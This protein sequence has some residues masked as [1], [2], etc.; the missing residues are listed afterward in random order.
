MRLKGLVFL[1]VCVLLLTCQY[2]FGQC[3]VSFVSLGKGNLAIHKKSLG[4]KKHQFQWPK[5]NFKLGDQIVHKAKRFAD[6]SSCINYKVIWVWSRCGLKM[7]I[8]YPL[9]SWAPFWRVYLFLDFSCIHLNFW[10]LHHFNMLVWSQIWWVSWSFQCWGLGE[11]MNNSCKWMSWPTTTPSMRVTWH[12]M[13]GQ[14]IATSHD[15]TP[16]GGSVMEFSYFREI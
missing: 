2:C 1:C 6:V 10:G 13:S 8:G 12:R 7:R 5:A 16:N 3:F 4:G 9:T 14:I 15:L 11:C